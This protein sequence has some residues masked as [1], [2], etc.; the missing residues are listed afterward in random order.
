MSR[1][2]FE[3]RIDELSPRHKEV[4]ALL[5]EAKSNKEI[6]RLLPRHG[7]E[8]GQHISESTVK[9]YV[10]DILH[11]LG[12]NSRQEAGMLWLKYISLFT[13]ADRPPPI[14]PRRSAGTGA[15]AVG[16]R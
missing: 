4:L 7:G 16:V 1:E 12:V 5:G 14:D 11:A 8:A 15:V 3:A 2:E 6:A 9:S 10:E 13:P